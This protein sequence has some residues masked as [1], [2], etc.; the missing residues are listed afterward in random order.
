MDN[1]VSE[2]LVDRALHA[3]QNNQRGAGFNDFPVSVLARA[4]GDMGR[5]AEAH[6]LVIDYATKRRRYRE[7]LSMC[8]REVAADAGLTGNSFFSAT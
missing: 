1:P 4:L 3:Y 6:Q 5:T 7:P 2:D 8:L